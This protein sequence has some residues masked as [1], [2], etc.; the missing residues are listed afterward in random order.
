MRK[1][2]APMTVATQS[3][4]LTHLRRRWLRGLPLALGAVLALSA[5]E[6]EPILPGERFD[7]SVPLDEAFA[8]AQSPADTDRS[9]PISFGGAQRLDVWGQRNLS[10]TNRIPHAA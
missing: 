9:A 6:R 5:C 4:D 3:T 7:A 8:G 10:V 1:A 2:G